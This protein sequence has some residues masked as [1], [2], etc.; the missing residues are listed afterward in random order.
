MAAFLSDKTSTST[1]SVP[2]EILAAVSVMGDVPK[3]VFASKDTARW[4]A[5][6]APGTAKS[7]VMAPPA[8]PVTKSPFLGETKEEAAAAGTRPV[9]IPPMAPIFPPA[10]G[11][12]PVFGGNAYS[13]IRETPAMT[14]KQ[15]SP[16][17]MYI[18]FGVLLLLVIAGG[19]V[20]WYFLRYVP[21]HSVVAD[22]VPI[23]PPPSMEVP[24]A[25]EPPYALDKPNYLSIDVETITTQEF[26]KILQA[27]SARMKTANMVKPVEFLITDKNNNPLAL[28]RFVYLMGLSLPEPL[29]TKLEDDFSVFAHNDKG[30]ATLGLRLVFTDAL[31]GGVVVKQREVT[32]PMMFRPLLYVGV[33]VPQKVLFRSG[34]Y[35]GET[36]R[37]VNLDGTESVSFDYVLRENTWFIGTTKDT[38]RVILDIKR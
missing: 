2:S 34:V 27:A 26:Q 6:S 8:A 10:P 4:G 36:V 32:L 23:A 18:I 9:K 5:V 21:A 14:A 31:V 7:S 3:A 12:K 29:M 24:V 11:D 30:K 1:G 15:E 17:M 38:L 25:I 37:F 22:P 35:N 33:T 13:G 20:A 28:S 19:G 16:M